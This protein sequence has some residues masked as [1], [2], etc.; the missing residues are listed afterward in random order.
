MFRG[1]PQPAG[2]IPQ[3]FGVT[4]LIIERSGELAGVLSPWHWREANL[5]ASGEVVGWRDP[6]WNSPLSL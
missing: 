4:A 6:F 2:G 5:V 1:G 3:R